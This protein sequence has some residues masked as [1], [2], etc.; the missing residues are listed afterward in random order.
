MKF[1]WRA[2][3]FTMGCLCLV[4]PIYGAGKYLQVEYP[5]S[6]A[7]NQLQIGVTYTM[8]IPDEVARFRCVIVHQHG[9]G[10]N[11]AEHGGTAAYDLH[12]Q[13]LA[14]KWDCA[15]LGPFYHV[16]TDATD[17]SPGG[18]ELWF[19]P[20]RGSDKTFLKALDELSAQAKHPELATVPWA[21]WGHSGGGIWSDVM[22]TLYPDRV[23][24][25]FLRSGSFRNRPD[26]PQPETPAAAY[27]VPVMGNA[28]V[29]EQDRNAWITTLARTREYRSKGGPAGFA[30]DPRTGHETGDSRYLAI[31]FLDACLAMRLPAKG[32]T[33]QNLKPVDVSKGW[34]APFL[35]QTAVPTPSY[36]GNPLEAVWLPNEHVA[37]IWIE[38]VKNGTVADVTPPPPPFNVRV[39]SISGGGNEITWDA[40]ADFESGIGGFFVMRDNRAIARLPRTTDLVL[41]V[42]GRPL[43]QGLSYHDT[44]EGPAAAPEMRYLD[45]SAKP[46]EKHTYSV[47]SINSAG[48]ASEPSAVVVVPSTE[49]GKD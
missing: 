3:V 19:D 36:K 47:L 7:P 38:Y 23:A 26:F 33:S 2:L 30:A 42:Y 46:G 45:V 44:P 34:L 10:K 1:N 28:G 21:L 24:A 31:P 27:A 35:G 14:K 4:R 12:W 20:R 25:A 16:L 37:K 18:S 5:P 11:A 17:A 32:S 9:A 15:L 13:A 43:F 39:K 29:K 48:V 49:F 22:A 8:W 40:E 41:I 6:T